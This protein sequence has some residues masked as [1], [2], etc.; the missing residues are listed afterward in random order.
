L[1]KPYIKRIVIILLFIA[2]VCSLLSCAK[3]NGIPAETSAAAVPP[4]AS[5]DDTTA[6]VNMLSTHTLSEDEK[7]LAD[8]LLC[9]AT[10]SAYSFNVGEGYT[11]VKVWYEKYE[12]GKLVS[13]GTSISCDISKFSGTG[14]MAV[15][16]GDG[17]TVRISLMC[18]GNSSRSVQ[19]LPLADSGEPP[20]VW[21][22]TGEQSWTT[23]ILPD[24]DITFLAYVGNT[25][26][27]MNEVQGVDTFNLSENSQCKYAYI[28]KCRFLTD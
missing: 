20:I 5:P 11:G 28:F 13:T 1:K 18:L 15:V 6:A 14:D 26:T 7:H 25:A 24:T 4:S 12:N 19:D 22:D 17:Q 8:L 21:S 2:A 3:R 23:D 16:L 27:S 9:G 10:F